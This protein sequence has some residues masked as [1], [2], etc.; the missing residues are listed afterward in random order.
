MIRDIGSAESQKRLPSS[1]LA[2]QQQIGFAAA[3]RRQPS[4]RQSD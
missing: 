1:Y 4:K 3:Q 2:P